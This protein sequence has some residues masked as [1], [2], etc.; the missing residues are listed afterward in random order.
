MSP[1]HLS[2]SY[3]NYASDI[4][5]ELEIHRY[6]Q[7]LDSDVHSDESCCFV[8]VQ[9]LQMSPKPGSFVKLV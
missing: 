2:V 9:A 5:D 3:S 4:R 6:R 8:T 7:A 1:G